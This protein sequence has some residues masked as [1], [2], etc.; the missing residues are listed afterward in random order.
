[1]EKGGT[2]WLTGEEKVLSIW[3]KMKLDSFFETY[4]KTTND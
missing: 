4:V 2:I 3:E 1:M